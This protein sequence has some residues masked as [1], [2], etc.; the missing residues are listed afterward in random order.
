MDLKL[1]DKI[2]FISASSKGIGR[3][4]AQLFLEEGATVIISSSLQDN[5]AK[6]ISELDGNY[7]NKLYGYK[8]DINN[9][10]EINTVIQSVIE[11]FGRIDVLVNNC[12]GPAPGTFDTLDEEKWKNGF[13]QVL[14]SAVRFCKVVLPS[15]KKNNWGRIIN[16]TSLSVKQPVDNLMLSNSFRTGLTGFAKTLSNE[17]GQHNITVNNVAPGFTLTG[18][19]EEIANISANAASISQEEQLKIMGDSVPMRRIGHVKEVG[20]AVVFLASEQAGY[21]TGTT[22]Q[23]D[24]GAIKSTF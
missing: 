14:M 17:V 23:V 19:L 20:A 2:V 9:L 21:I 16:I 11:Q 22:I 5:V 13:E 18:R 24:G 12:G 1:K 3:A 8:C 6:T 7:K 15:M 10:N 4:T